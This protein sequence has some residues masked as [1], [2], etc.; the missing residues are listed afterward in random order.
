MKNFMFVPKIYKNIG[1]VRTVG[2]GIV[3]IIGLQNICYGEMVQF[4]NREFGL[5]L[6]LE[7]NRV[8]VIV[9]GKDIAILPGDVV[10]RTFNLMNLYAGDYLLGCIVDPLGR[11]LIDLLKGSR[12]SRPLFGKLE[13]S[14]DYMRGAVKGPIMKNFLLYLELKH[15]LNMSKKCSF[16]TCLRYFNI[17][18]KILN[19]DVIAKDDNLIIKK[20]SV[21]LRNT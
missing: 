16:S 20:K 13:N 7:T 18:K 9:L 3:S 2:D 4:P 8:S 6:N 5:V 15:F 17:S 10:A 14:F 1:F 11:V 12:G 21:L 19:I